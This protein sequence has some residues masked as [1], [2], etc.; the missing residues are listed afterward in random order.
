M[1]SK[2]KSNKAGKTEEPQVSYKSASAKSVYAFSS[3]EELEEHEARYMASLSPLEHLRNATALIKRVFAE[4]LKKN[5]KLGR[6]IHIR[7]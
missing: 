2:K 5:P 7:K 3:F 4:D 6:K 1:K